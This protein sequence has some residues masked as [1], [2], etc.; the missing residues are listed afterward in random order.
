V[1]FYAF[2]TRYSDH[3]HVKP[4]ETSEDFAKVLEA[5]KSPSVVWVLRSFEAMN[6]SDAESQA[7]QL[8]AAGHGEQSW[9]AVKQ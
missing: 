6:F 4:L 2:Q 3:L 8:K 1:N 9:A 7:K 5:V